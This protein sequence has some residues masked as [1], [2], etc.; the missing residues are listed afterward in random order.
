MPNGN[1]GNGGLNLSIK[2][3][4]EHIDQML[5]IMG[6]PLPLP[7]GDP[8]ALNPTPTQGDSGGQPTAAFDPN[9]PPPGTIVS[10]VTGIAPLTGTPQYGS[11]SQSALPAVPLPAATGTAVPPAQPWRPPT[12]G[13][14]TE[15]TLAGAAQALPTSESALG[16]IPTTP[17]PTQAGAIQPTKGQRFLHALGQIAGTA[18]GAVAPGVAMQIPQT[19]LGKIAAANRTMMQQRMATE[20]EKQKAETLTAQ[21]EASLAPQ[22]I[23][24]MQAQA[25]E[26]KAQA[27]LEGD[28]LK[29][30]Q[31]QAQVNQLQASARDAAA[32]ASIREVQAALYKR[33]IS[34]PTE[35][36]NAVDSVI[37]PQKYPELNKRAKAMVDMARQADPTDLQAPIKA[38]TQAAQEV[39]TIDRETDPQVLNARVN[40]AVRTQAALTKGSAV[41][42]VPPHLVAAATTAANK[43]GEDYATLA[44]QMRN[45]DNMLSDAKNGDQVAAAFGPV[46]AVL[47]SNAFYGTHRFSPTELQTIQGLGSIG[48]QFNAWFDKNEKGAITPDSL[49]E[50]KSM[51]ARLNSV[52]NL[53]YKNK[54]KVINQNYGSTF[55][56]VE[57]DL[58]EAAPSAGA[59][60]ASAGQPPAGA[61]VRSWSELNQ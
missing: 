15:Q 20:L 3:Q 7:Q 10:N 58:G 55:T 27:A 46:A 36:T 22:R 52:G 6:V 53:Q 37:D 17:Q 21:T 47:G 11:Q 34:N 28:P 42:G 31:L 12:A 49:K 60:V 57:F 8:A 43:A 45:V 29:K 59:G 50:F 40:T 41:A 5:G 25:D 51:V 23:Q 56:P 19:P 2:G 4:P 14:T 48:R 18:L 38:L 1:G 61:K 26:A 9:N 35:L 13:P 39:D 24:L 32:Q 16:A 44:G 54:L 33:D 30:Q